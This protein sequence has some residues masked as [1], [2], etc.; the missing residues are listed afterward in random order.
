MNNNKRKNI[1]ILNLII[2]ANIY[3]SFNIESNNGLISGKTDMFGHWQLNGYN[4]D[5][6]LP[7]IFVNFSMSTLKNNIGI[8]NSNDLYI[9]IMS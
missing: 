8:S 1:L 5:I 6:K 9:S 2:S 7:N 3:I 4:N